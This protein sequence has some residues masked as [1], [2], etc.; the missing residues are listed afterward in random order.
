[1]NNFWQKLNKPI[2]GLAPM[3][4]VTDEPM[5][6][7]QCSIAKPDVLYTEFIQVEGFVRKPKVFK[8][9]LTFKESERPIIAQVVGCTPADFSK[10]VSEIAKMGFDGIDINMGCPNKDVFS[11][12]AG[13]ALIGNYELA[14]EIINVSLRAI[15][16]KLPLSIK[17]RIGKNT[18]IAEEWFGFLSKFPLAEVTIHGRLVTQVHGG[19]V[20]W[21]AITLGANILK[22][23]S[24]LCLGNGGIKNRSEAEE[25]CREL[26]LDGI[27]IG[28]AA[29]GNPWVFLKDYK[30]T[31]K[32]ILETILKHGQLSWNFH[33]P[34]KY[35]TVL[36]HYSWYP[37]EF[38][39]SKDLRIKLLKTRSFEEVQK[40]I[41]EENY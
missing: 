15:D 36:K 10:A 9:K 35:A 18:S 12:G 5:R 40:V 23:K 30:P 39:N 4:G 3:D 27:L 25:K 17:T 16:G 37:R 6:Q 21:D 22:N 20:N 32:E 33:G 29:L 2:I 24:I 38:P 8:D 31:K 7:V 14:E 26:N 41:A 28:Q 1:M 19:E 13:G 11:R 34:K